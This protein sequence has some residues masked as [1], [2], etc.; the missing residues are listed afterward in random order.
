M[1]TNSTAFKVFFQNV[2][3]KGYFFTLIL[4]VKSKFQSRSV[5]FAC[6]VWISQH[7]LSA[8]MGGIMLC[9]FPLHHQCILNPCL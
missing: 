8:G 2:E 5:S 7:F 4:A 1:I 9:P 6:Y 3:N